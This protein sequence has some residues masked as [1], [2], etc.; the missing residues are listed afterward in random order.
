MPLT[1]RQDPKPRC[2]GKCYLQVTRALRHVLQAPC[3]VP[4]RVFSP[5]VSPIVGTVLPSESVVVNSC[6]SAAELLCNFICDC[7]DC[8]DENQCGGCLDS[9]GPPDPPSGPALGVRAGYVVGSCCGCRSLEWCWC[10][11]WMQN[12]PGWIQDPRVAADPRGR[13]KSLMWVSRLDTGRLGAGESAR[14]VQDPRLCA[15]PWGWSQVSWV[16]PNLP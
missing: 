15:G 16:A 1:A 10:P 12:P 7:S 9:P 13:D 3:L 5:I 4:C 6:S 11:G 2:P 8:S 14:W